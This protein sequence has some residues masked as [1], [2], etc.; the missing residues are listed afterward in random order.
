MAEETDDGFILWVREGI[1]D[2]KNHIHQFRNHRKQ[3]PGRIVGVHWW[4]VACERMTAGE[5][6]EE[7]MADYGWAKC[8][9]SARI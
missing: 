9:S 7:V 5:P 3:L 6:V 8:N 2:L 4:Q 1:A